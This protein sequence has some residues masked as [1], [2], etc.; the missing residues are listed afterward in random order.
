MTVTANNKA[1]NGCKQTRIKLSRTKLPEGVRDVRIELGAAASM[2]QIAD[3]AVF[4]KPGLRYGGFSQDEILGFT[5]RLDVGS[6][7]CR[8][9]R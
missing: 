5:I 8:A 6:L 4:R 7:L 9:S 1:V 2:H 3:K